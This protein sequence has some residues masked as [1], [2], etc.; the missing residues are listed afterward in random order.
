MTLG[1]SQGFEGKEETW[2]TLGTSHFHG[3]GVRSGWKSFLILSKYID[4]V[5][6]VSRLEKVKMG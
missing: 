2:M 1:T 4:K 5:H 3:R 6:V